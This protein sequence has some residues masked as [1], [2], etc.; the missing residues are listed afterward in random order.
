MRSKKPV[1]YLSFGCVAAIVAVLAV[2]RQLSKAAEPPP[3]VEQVALLQAARDIGYGE[4]ISLGGNNQDAN[5]QVVQWP[6]AAVPHGAISDT[7][8]VTDQVTRARAEIAKG[9]LILERRVANDQDFVPGDMCTEMVR[10]GQD[11][12]NSRR[13]RPGIKVDVLRIEGSR[14]VRFMRCV[15]IYA[16]GRLD[17]F[18]HAVGGGDLQPNVFLLIKKSDQ[19][20]FIEAQLSGSFR[21]VESAGACGGGPELVDS[22]DTPEMRQKEAE[23]L[24][25]R[26]RKLGEAGD[27]QK[28][29]AELDQVVKQYA[30][31]TNVVTEATVLSGQYRQAAASSLYN[32]AEQ[33]YRRDKQYGIAMD[34]LDQLERDY[35]E[36][37]E[38]LRKAAQLRPSIEAD[39]GRHEEQSRYEALLKDVEAALANGNLP[40]AAE[41]V[42]EFKRFE[43]AGFEPEGNVLAPAAAVRQLSGRLRNDENKY[44]LDKAVL[45]SH[46]KKNDLAQ[47]RGKLRQMKERFPAHPGIAELE[48]QVKRASEE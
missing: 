8:V 13:L 24:L 7:A 42:Q 36:V 6:K 48:E 18:G 37:E 34:L 40:L 3:A 1:L 30:D 28:A 23:N 2:N 20:P 19:V 9:E 10:V 46:L 17:L 11:D 22:S 35:A 41:K 43:A 12:V 14:A 38:V 29:L 32:A 45:E 26:A 5:V 15:R 31:L 33:A 27:H 44:D 47:A 4:R 25:E 21:L 39:R 16:I